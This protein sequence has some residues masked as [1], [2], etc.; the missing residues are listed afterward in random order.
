[1]NGSFSRVAPGVIAGAMATLAMSSVMIWARR[2]GVMRRDYPPRRITRKFLK[3]VADEPSRPALNAVTTL[4]HFGYGVAGGGVYSAL[5]AKPRNPVV[6]GAL[7]GLAVW[8]VSYWGWV[9]ALRI[10]PPPDD[11]QR[12]RVGTMV[13]AHVIYGA[14]LGYCESRLRNQ[15]HGGRSRVNEPAL[16]LRQ[17]LCGFFGNFDLG[18]S[19][20]L[21]ST[22]VVRSIGTS[23]PFWFL[24]VPLLGT[25]IWTGCRPLSKLGRPLHQ[26]PGAAHDRRAKTG[27]TP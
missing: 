26:S 9:P 3:A 23:S 16:C 6:A 18:L 15:V 7:Y 19:T 21:I 5:T 10:M 8:A 11:D 25:R 17:L 14:V 1:M 2:A 13:A 24:V 22:V 20:S 12:G 27:E 4:T